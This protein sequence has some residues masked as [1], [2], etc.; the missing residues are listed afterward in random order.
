MGRLGPLRTLT[1][2]PNRH[3]AAAHPVSLIMTEPRRGNFLA[4]FSGSQR[5]RSCLALW[6]TRR[7]YPSWLHY[8]VAQSN[9]HGRAPL[10]S[11]PL[12][13][14]PPAIATVCRLPVPRKTG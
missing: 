6:L 10:L 12:R 7:H 2:S 11:P 5:R 8:L 1:L 3:A 13:G 9:F 4:A 14:A